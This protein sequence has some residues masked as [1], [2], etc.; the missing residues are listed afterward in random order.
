MF[1]QNQCP[2]AL[3]KP[4][5]MLMR[6]G[7]IGLG[8]MG[9]GMARSLMRAGHEVIA[10]NRTRARAEALARVGAKLAATV[11]EACQADMVFTM[12]AN[13]EA[14]EA[15]A[16]GKDG[17]V[18]NLPARAIHIS[19]STISVDLSERLAAAHTEAGQRYVVATVLGRPDRAAEGQLFVIAA[20]APDALKDVRPLLDAVGQGTTEFG[21]RPS[22]ANLVKL[23]ANFLLATV[24]ESLGEA[25]AL[26]AKDGINKRHYVDFLTSTMFGSPAYKVYGGLVAADEEPP[27]GFAAPLGLKD[28]R[29]ALAAADKL[30]VPM[31]FAS[32]LHDRFVELLATNGENHDWSAVGRMALRDS[33]QA[34]A[35]EP[36]PA[37]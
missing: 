14:V 28:I 23:S 17:I 19:S 12:L 10:Y 13:D 31:P 21:D 11:A 30:E 22:N 35:R 20:G 29:L 6:V 3:I 24:F 7:F 16:L 9:S 15:I 8:R 27:V 4:Q 26:I 33:G 34:V 32:V 5:E 1:I 37:K 36:V 18:E 25:V 2:I